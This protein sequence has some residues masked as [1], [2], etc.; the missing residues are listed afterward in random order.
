MTRSLLPAGCIVVGVDGSGHSERA[1]RWGA[2]QAALE[3]R[4]VAL[5]HVSD[6]M[7]S[8]D[9]TLLLHARQQ[10]ELAVP[11]VTVITDLVVAD[12]RQ[13]L[14]EM[15][16]AAHLLVVGS[17]GRGALRSALLGSVSVAVAKHARCPVVVCRPPDPRT[18]THARVIVGADGSEA[19]RPALEFAFAQASLRGVPLTVMHCF[20]DVAAA[21]AGPGEVTAEDED[22]ADL[23]LLLA[24]SVAGLQ[25]KYPDVVVTREL[26]RGL[27]DECLAGRAP[28]ADLIVVGRAADHSWSRFMHASCALAVAERARAAVAVVPESAREEEQP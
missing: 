14:V 3:G 7:S 5:V 13:V 27:V 18:A 10:A 24:E 21:I 9:T 22:L 4:K 26:A 17:R 6:H 28:D 1:V 20:W 16:G 15:S 23:R 25:E 12:P 8:D 11:G 2:T 19:G